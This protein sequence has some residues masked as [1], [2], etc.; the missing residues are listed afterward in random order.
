[1]K[2]VDC[3]I[4]EKDDLNADGRSLW[5][6]ENYKDIKYHHLQSE[7][8][9]VVLRSGLIFLEKKNGSLHLLKNRYLIEL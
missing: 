9:H 2:N 1:M 3:V 6:F 5:E 7:P 4:M 8:A